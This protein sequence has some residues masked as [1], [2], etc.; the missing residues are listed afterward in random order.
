V[1]SGLGASWRGGVGGVDEGVVM[2]ATLASRNTPLGHDSP[3]R[4]HLPAFLTHRDL[5]QFQFDYLIRR[6]FVAA[7]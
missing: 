4:R 6:I 5:L 7:G 2:A 3:P 1:S